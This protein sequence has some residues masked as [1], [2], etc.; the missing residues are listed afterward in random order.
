MAMLAD[1][2][3]TNSTQAHS[4][5]QSREQA[6]ADF[7]DVLPNLAH[8]IHVNVRFCAP[9][10]FEFT[11]EV[12][13]FDLFPRVT[14]LHGWLIDPQ[15]ARLA[16]AFGT[17]SYNQVVDELV[18]TATPGFCENNREDEDALVHT[19]SAPPIDEIESPH[20]A[21][22]DPSIEESEYTVAI[23]ELRPHV[24]EFLESNSTMLTVYGLTELHSVVAE[25]THAILFRNSHFYVLRKWKGELFTLVTDVGYLNEL[26][27]VWEKLADVTGD[28][29]FYDA[30]FR[31]VKNDGTV[32]DAVI[33]TPSRQNGSVMPFGQGA[34]NQQGSGAPPREQ[35]QR[36]QQQASQRPVSGRRAFAPVGGRLHP[37]HLPNIGGTPA[38][39]PQVNGPERQRGAKGEK[40][41][42]Q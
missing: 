24:V 3:S 17:L 22:H 38:Q 23:R 7:L 4:D 14:L 1:F 11:K 41:V 28:S 42:V 27:T 40:C 21:V 8:G 2:I 30:S 32:E 35:Q 37:G 12:A 18:R 13:V 16:A 6:V 29:V 15:D 10:A 33:A 9:S 26:N 34:T 36:Q 25:G 39:R 31:R 5:P 20:P 19:P